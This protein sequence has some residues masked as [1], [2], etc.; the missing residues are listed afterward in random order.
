M[1]E[2]PPRG[3]AAVAIPARDEAA[4]IGPVVRGCRALGLVVWVVD[5]GSAD[6][7]ADAARAAGAEVLPHPRNLGKGAAIRTALA[8]FLASPHAALILMDAD[9]QHDPRFIPDFLR[10]AERADLVLGDRMGDAAAMPRVRRWTNRAMS[11][12]LGAL[13]RTRIPDSQCGYRLLTRRFAEAFR[14]TTSHFEL[15]SEMLVQ[16][17][18]LGFPL[19]AVPIPAV[20]G[21]APSH[22]RPLRDTL[23]FL[24]FLLECRQLPR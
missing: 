19:A 7:T 10:A 24:R 8:R 9:G 21:P 14:P 20:Y 23:R 12:L 17:A 16:A 4:R 18:R 5:D 11:R 6:G 2:L 3:N 13:C 22:I 1:T 15:E